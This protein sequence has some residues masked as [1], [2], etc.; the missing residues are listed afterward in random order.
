MSRPN[1]VIFMITLMIG[2]I[3]VG[4]MLSTNYEKPIEYER[5]E[6]LQ[7][8]NSER[9][10][11]KLAFYLYSPG[12]VHVTHYKKEITCKHCHSPAVKLGKSNCTSCHSKQDF[13][14][15]SSTSLLEETHTTLLDQ[16]TC[17]TCHTEH[18]GAK[19][20][21]TIPLQLDEHKTVIPKTIK[22]KCSACHR[23]EGKKAHENMDSDKCNDCHKLDEPFNW[24]KADFKHDSIKKLKINSS[25]NS[26]TNLPI[27]ENG[28]C[29]SCHE[30][31][32]HVIDRKNE[33]D[34]ITTIEGKFDCKTCHNFQNI[35]E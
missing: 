19:G 12:E 4:I 26:F 7:A 27:P 6:K 34:Y 16:G 8:G 10:S 18:Q 3:L 5:D 11:S 30:K 33:K 1:R 14:E 28:E 15:N 13:K 35:N 23:S 17:L 29:E 9:L 31:G 21:I 20:K 32:F 2:I 25:L 24:E 22:K